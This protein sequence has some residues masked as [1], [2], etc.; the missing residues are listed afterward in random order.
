MKVLIDATWRMIVQLHWYRATARTVA[1]TS[2]D[3]T[4]L[5][6]PSAVVSV[7]CHVK[8]SPSKIRPSSK[9]FDRLLLLW[10]ISNSI[11]YRHCR[12]ASLS[13]TIGYKLIISHDVSEMSIKFCFLTRQTRWRNLMTYQQ[14]RAVCQLN[15]ES[16]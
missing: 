11:T 9:F 14:V 4:V 6:G 16:G 12:C 2:T 7:E 8:F 3:A 13:L 15:R 5:D 1:K 10:D